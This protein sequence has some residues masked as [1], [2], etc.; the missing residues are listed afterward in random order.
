[1]N[2]LELFETQYKNIMT[3][4]SE[5]KAETQKQLDKIIAD[6]EELK[7]KPAER[8]DKATVTAMTTIISAVVGYIVGKIFGG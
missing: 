8:W 1:M 7:Q 3:A 2:G 6:I 5:Q 4:L